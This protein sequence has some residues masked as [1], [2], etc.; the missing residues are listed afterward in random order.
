MRASFLPGRAEASRWV[1]ER[2]PARGVLGDHEQ[3]TD[4][5]IGPCARGDADGAVARHCV[6]STYHSN[7]LIPCSSTSFNALGPV[8]CPISGTPSALSAG[9]KNMSAATN[10]QASRGSLLLSQAHP[11]R[12]GQLMVQ[13]V[14]RSDNIDYFEVTGRG[15][16]QKLKN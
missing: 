10:S 1:T 3:A 4:S 5:R 11:A 15:E 9:M 13:D 6:C 14:K 2:R 8:A 12:P 16:G 7:I